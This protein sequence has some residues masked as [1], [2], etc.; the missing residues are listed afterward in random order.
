LP[1]RHGHFHAGAG[2]VADSVPEAEYDETLAKARGFLGA[3][4]LELPVEQF[5]RLPPAD[6][7]GI[8]PILKSHKRTNY[9][10]LNSLFI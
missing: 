4:Q 1:R 9:G 2:I 8:D 3:L 7:A 5:P 6:F 10:A